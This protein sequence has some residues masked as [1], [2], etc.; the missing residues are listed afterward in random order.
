MN[1]VPKRY[2]RN[3]GL[4]GEEGQR[5]LSG[6]TVVLAG[7][8]GLGTP[9]AQQLAFLG[10]GHMGLIDPEE[11]DDTNRNRFVG[12]RE[13]DP[14]PGSLKVDLV[15][16]MIGEINSAVKVSA[17]PQDLI[18]EE[19]FALIK[20][21]DW[22]F[23]CFDEDGPRFVLNELCSAYGIPYIDLASDVLENGS[24]GGRVCTAWDGNG[25]LHCL[26]EL[27]M[28][29]V[30]TYLSSETERKAVDRIY[31][32]KR[33]DLGTSG[34]SVAPLNAL[35]T[36]HAAVEFMVAATG[37]RPPTRLIKYRGDVPRTTTSR[38]T[39]EKGCPYCKEIRRTQGDADVE[40]YL[41]IPHLNPAKRLELRK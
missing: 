27:D 18:T 24:F 20:A 38:D 31:G 13:R 7:V 6:T 36:G 19:S 22:V 5:K 28:E 33:D 1:G 4:F 10:V 2:E 32:V 15:E 3:L 9:L 34:P 29:D 30:R 35:I 25:C 8:S 12:A 26:D 39:P 16:R 37:L 21:A 23:G 40:R 17:L 41:R 14:V 11:L